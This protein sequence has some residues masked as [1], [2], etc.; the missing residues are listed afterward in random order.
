MWNI[1]IYIKKNLVNTIPIAMALGIIFGYF[2]NPSFLKILIL[3]LTIM[4]IYPMMVTLNIKTLFS[5]CRPKT[6]VIIQLVN[7]II[8]PLVGFGLGLLFFKNSPY[9]AYGLLLIALLPTSG[10]TI[11]WTG[12]AKGN[13]NIAI[14]T[15]IIGLILGSLLMPFYTKFFMGQVISLPLIK[16]FTQLGKVI[17]LPLFLGFITQIILKKIYGEAHFN[18]DIKKKFPLLSTLAVLGIIF[19]A[20]ALKAKSIIA[21]PLSII[22]LL[23]PLSIFYIFNYALSSIIGKLFL[24]RAESIALVYGSVMRNLSIA[25]A[26]ALTVFGDDGV[27]IA[28]IVAVAYIIQV[29]SAA[30]YI[31]FSEKIFGTAPEDT[32][33]DIMK[34]GVFSLHYGQTVN[35]AI[36]L[37]DEE[38][39]HSIAVLDNKENP[40]GLITAEML[41]NLLAEGKKQ[42]SKLKSINLLPVIQFKETTPIKKVIETMKRKHEY[43][44]LITDE[45]GN[46]EGVLTKSNILDKYANGG[47]N[48]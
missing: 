27:E 10:M 3:P 19:V 46:L 39:I 23:V 18:K 35:D 17:F 12:F 28:L 20:M 37:I 22:Y 31:K 5:Y 24:S 14:K 7:F 30:W 21:N 13:V 47:K 25:L 44:V 43:K 42:D 38:H 33:K 15:T 36:R 32:A 48:E 16:T 40:V 4:M 41:I 29:Q 1:L 9:L 11:S 45:K 8:I 26:I 34:K 6:Q 2:Y